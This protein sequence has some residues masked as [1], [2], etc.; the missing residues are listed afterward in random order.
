[1]SYQFG[2][3][4]FET[5]ER[6]LRGIIV[7]W[8]DPL[9]DEEVIEEYGADGLRVSILDDWPNVAELLREHDLDESDLEEAAEAY[10]AELQEEGPRHER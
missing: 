10:V 2:G 1:M 8:C 9:T 6:L 5:T 3:V 4:G 7:K